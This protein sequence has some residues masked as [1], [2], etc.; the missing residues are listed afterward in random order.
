MKARKRKRAKVKTKP[1]MPPKPPPPKARPKPSPPPE[2]CA[3]CH[4]MSLSRC[5][6]YP[7]SFRSRDVALHPAVAADGWCGK[8]KAKG[9]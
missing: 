8:W 6:Y 4:Y 7:P 3:G 9:N 2:T 5:R 1:P